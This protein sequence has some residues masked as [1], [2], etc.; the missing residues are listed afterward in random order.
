MTPEGLAARWEEFWRRD[1]VPRILRQISESAA[2]RT[3]LDLAMRYPPAHPKMRERCDLLLDRL[4]QLGSSTQPTA[5][6]AALREAA[7]VQ[8]GGTKKDWV[9]EQVYGR[10]RDA[11]KALRDD[12]DEVE[13]RLQFD[14]AAARPAAAMALELLGLAGDVARHYAERKRALGVLD[15]DDLLIR[16]RQLLVGPEQRRA[17]QTAGG[18][19]PA[20]AGRRVP[21]YRR[22]AG[23]NAQGA[24]RQRVSP[25]QAVL[26]GRLQAVDLSFPR[27]TSRMFFGSCAERF[28]RRAKCRLRRTSAAN[29][30][31]WSSSTPCL[32]TN[33]GR[34]TSR[35]GRAARRSAGRRRSSSSGHAKSPLFLRERARV[36][37]C[38]NC[39]RQMPSP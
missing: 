28:R 8:G 30:P 17:A 2:A 6:L 29:R 25:R 12:I 23:R 13:S 27:R 7:K 20:A 34:T 9:N 18:P 32:V 31:C 14:P 3:V 10:F 36:R 38:L 21:G 35:F 22:A 16:A 33:L 4:P 39:R 26:R 5:E 1:T 24:L 19:D 11:A 15:F 37:A